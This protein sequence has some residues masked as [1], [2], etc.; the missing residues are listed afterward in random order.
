MTTSTN[1]VISFGVVC[2][3]DTEFPWEEDPW[4]EDLEDWWRGVNGFKALHEPYTPEGEYAEGWSGDDPRLKEMWEQQRKWDEQNPIP[5]ELEN[6]CSDSYPMYAFVVP[7]VGYK[8]FRGYPEK[9]DQRQLTVTV[10]Q[11]EDL[12]KFLQTYNIPYEDE[13][14]WLLTSYWG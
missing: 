10:K 1:G 5:V 11:Q 9:L 4:E 14:T 6:Y 12:L 13:P 7:S 8:C 2:K 3:E